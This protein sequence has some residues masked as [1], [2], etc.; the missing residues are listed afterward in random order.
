MESRCALCGCKTDSLDLTE[1]TFENKTTATL[2]GYCRRQL[3]GFDKN[4]QSSAAWAQALL[5]AN[6]AGA[7]TAAQAAVC[8]MLYKRN[9]PR[10]SPADI[11][12]PQPPEAEDDLEQIK[13]RLSAL[14]ADYKRFKRR[15]MILKIVGA[16]VPIIFVV[17]MLIILFASGAFQ[18]L[19]DYYAQLS[20]YANL[21]IN[22]S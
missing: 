2:C 10:Q 13:K 17:L 8:A 1:Y 3:D 18:N 21:Q 11:P 16:V 5:Q 19:L 12:A 20:D 22:L 7:Q 9:F 6:A 15:Y 4:P 14:E